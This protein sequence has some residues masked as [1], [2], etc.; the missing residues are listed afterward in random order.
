[1]EAY[2]KQEHLVRTCTYMCACTCTYKKIVECNTIYHM[3]I[4]VHVYVSLQDHIKHCELVT[5]E[6]PYDCSVSCQRKELQP[7]LTKCPNRPTV[8]P[9]CNINFPRN[10]LSHHNQHC[11]HILLPATL[12]DTV[13]KVRH[14]NVIPDRFN[15]EYLILRNAY[16]SHIAGTNNCGI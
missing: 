8:C 14:A 3:F 4:H 16:P 6:C 9:Y 1:M 7:H 2:L 13:F 10:K 12:Q 11:S 15:Y 5:V